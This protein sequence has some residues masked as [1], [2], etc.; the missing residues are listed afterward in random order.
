MAKTTAEP[1]RT[2]S[3]SRPRK[4]NAAAH[5]R[6]PGHS[7]P[8]S[9]D[10]RT[11]V[12]ADGHGQEA[13]FG[14]PTGALGVPPVH[15]DGGRRLAKA[16]DDE[17]DGSAFGP[18]GIVVAFAV[19]M[20]TIRR[21]R[22]RN[23]TAGVRYC[24]IS[25]APGVC[26]VVVVEL[27]GGIRK[28]TGPRKSGLANPRDRI[29]PCFGWLDHRDKGT[30]LHEDGDVVQGERNGDGLAAFVARAGPEIEPDRI[31]GE[32]H[33]AVRWRPFP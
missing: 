29:G 19:E 25:T 22:V 26:A 9:T 11:A 23:G 10:A 3:W 21:H 20:D 31:P 15:A 33:E 2:P 17:P 30:G 5:K 12:P 24:F 4:A 1:G 6:S 16:M 8:I 28:R 7:T 32:R 27:A 13:F 14:I 18:A